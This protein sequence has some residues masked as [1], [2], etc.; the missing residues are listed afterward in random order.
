[1]RAAIDAAFNRA[2]H[3]VIDAHVT[4]SI[5]GITLYLYGTGPIQGFALT[6]LIGIVA[7][8]FT[9]LTFTR[10]VLRLVV[11]LR[12]EQSTKLYGV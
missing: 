3:T 5:A 6:L 1:L 12:S 2:F 8:L 7:S 10:Y 11:G 9:A 4:T